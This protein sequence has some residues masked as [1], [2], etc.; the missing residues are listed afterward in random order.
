MPDVRWDP[1]DEAISKSWPFTTQMVKFEKKSMI[2]HFVIKLKWSL[3]ILEIKICFVLDFLPL[4][5]PG[6][7]L[8]SL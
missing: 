3:V 4:V 6:P 2:F 7:F 1:S 8:E 5:L